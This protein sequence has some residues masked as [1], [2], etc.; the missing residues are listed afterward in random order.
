MLFAGRG[1][2]FD[3]LFAF[4]LFAL[5]CASGFF[6]AAR[7][8]VFNPVMEQAVRHSLVFVNWVKAPRMALPWWKRMA[9]PL[10]CGW[11]IRL[12]PEIRLFP[13]A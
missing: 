4:G 8:T 13:D 12:R 1:E 3:S 5:A 2:C 11:I 6:S 7:V 9:F 10:R